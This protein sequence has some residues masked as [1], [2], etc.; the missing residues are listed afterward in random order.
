MFN[1]GLKRFGG[2][3]SAEFHRDQA[4]AWFAKANAEAKKGNKK[5]WLDAY[6]EG[7]KHKWGA[8]QFSL[9]PAHRQALDVAS[10]NCGN[11]GQNL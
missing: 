7:A 11:S 4:L 3:V 5:K 1:I 2:S 8:E 6:Q 10:K 9:K